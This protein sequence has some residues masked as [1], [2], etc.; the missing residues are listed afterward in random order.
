MDAGWEYSRSSEI[1][2]TSQHFSA[3]MEAERAVSRQLRG[4]V[5]VLE[6]DLRRVREAQ[7]QLGRQVQQEQ[8][9][10][11]SLAEERQRL[12]Q[13]LE[14]LKYRL[15]GLRENRRAVNLESISLRRDR[16]HFSAELSFLQ[17]M[18]VEEENT[19]LTLH[20]T[21]SVLQKSYHSLEG[22]TEH[23]ERQRRELVQEV[24]SERESIRLE[25]RNN[26]E[27]RNRLDRL[28]REQ[29]AAVQSR[30]QE[31]ARKQQRSEMQNGL[32]NSA[33][34][35]SRLAANPSLSMPS[36][37]RQQNHTWAHTIAS[38]SAPATSPAGCAIGGCVP[39]AAPL[40]LATIKASP[41]L[42]SLLASSPGS[43]L[44]QLIAAGPTGREGV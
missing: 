9:Q 42:R 4:E 29:V 3:V 39:L 24:A 40:P 12:E 1:N 14:D 26:S 19:L 44:R 7:A 6:E 34:V 18:A 30:Q 33:V 5:D 15:A 25:E 20:H 31:F 11:S 32:E 17:K 2:S 16:D 27:I 38:K 41:Q 43:P 8:Q 28:R 23:L 10:A 35:A 13:Q 21:S 37:G 22:Q 36:E